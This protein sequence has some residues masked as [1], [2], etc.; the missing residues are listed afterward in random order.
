MHNYK[1]VEPPPD[2]FDTLDS[3]KAT[4]SRHLRSRTPNISLHTGFLFFDFLPS[5]NLDIGGLQ[6]LL[7]ELP[8][9]RL[10][11]SEEWT[12]QAGLTDGQLAQSGGQD[13]L[14]IVVVVTDRIEGVAFAG[15]DELGVGRLVT[16][17]VLNVHKVF[18]VRDARVF[19]KFKQA[20]RENVVI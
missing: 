6:I 1:T 3:T 13:L 16:G 7:Q 20:W 10:H 9:L 18:V 19:R 15:K 11:L 4:T 17:G 8:R 14:G 2:F 12:Q 5:N